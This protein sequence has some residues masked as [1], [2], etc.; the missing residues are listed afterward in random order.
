MAAARVQVLLPVLGIHDHMLVSDSRP[1]ERP[2]AVV[3]MPP[4]REA[5]MGNTRREYTLVSR[6]FESL[7]SEA[8]S[9]N[10]IRSLLGY[11]RDTVVPCLLYMLS[12]RAMWRARP[13][14]LTW[15]A[16][17]ESDETVIY[18]EPEGHSPPH[19]LC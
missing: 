14:R 16:I 5:L 4:H 18:G 6:A 2:L 10:F 1:E 8:S 17:P 19:L 7:M 9:T 3:S 12:L 11:I 13:S 15:P